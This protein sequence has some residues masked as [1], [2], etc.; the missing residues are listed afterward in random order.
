MFG[1]F[2]ALMGS[3]GFWGKS[4]R[5]LILGLDN[6]GKTTLLYRMKTGVVSTFVPTQRT[7]VEEFEHGGVSFKAFDVGGHEVV[8]KLWADF[9]TEVDAVVFVVDAADDERLAEARDALHKAA[10]TMATAGLE[11]EVQPPVPLLLLANKA[12]VPSAQPAVALE[13]SL[14]LRE[15]RRRRGGG[16]ATRLVACSMLSGVGLPEAFAWLTTQL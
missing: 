3:L 12:D 7:N 11:A 4:A 6:A 16:A 14:E 15:L 9:M 2:W 5:I 8:R 1:W 10:A 13:A